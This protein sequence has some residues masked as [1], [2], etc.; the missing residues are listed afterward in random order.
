MLIFCSFVG[1]LKKTYNSSQ[2]KRMLNSFTDQDITVEENHF[3][4]EAENN[5]RR[6]HRPNYGDTLNGSI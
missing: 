1:Q 6:F 4:S 2:K 3:K 5:K